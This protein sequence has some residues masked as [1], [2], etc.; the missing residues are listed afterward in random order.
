MLKIHETF[1]LDKSSTERLIVINDMLFINT[2]DY[3][4]LDRVLVGNKSTYTYKLNTSPNVG[5]DFI[6]IYQH[7][8]YMR[9]HMYVNAYVHINIY[10]I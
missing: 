5:D 10:Y 6:Y 7:I 2:L 3:N 4:G 8:L 1:L 9:I